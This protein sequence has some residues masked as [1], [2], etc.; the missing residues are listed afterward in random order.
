MT[1]PTKPPLKPSRSQWRAAALILRALKDL[2]YADR[3]DALAIACAAFVQ[4][5]GAIQ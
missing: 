1:Q 4:T 5:N 2:P 3:I